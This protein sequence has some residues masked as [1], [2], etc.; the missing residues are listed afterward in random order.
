MA[1]T[2]V[3]CVPSGQTAATVLRGTPYRI[4]REEPDLRLVILSPLVRD[5]A[6]VAEFSGPGVELRELVMHRPARLEGR[7]LRL[8]QASHLR[9]RPTPG[10]RVRHDELAHREGR[11]AAAAARALLARAPSRVWRALNDRLAPDRYY[12]DLFRTFRPALVL[13]P[14]PG[15]NFAELP[16]LKRARAAGVPAMAIDTSWD[17]FTRLEPIR[18]VDRLAV[19]NTTM[20]R[21]A[22]ELHGYPREAIDVCGVPQFD[23]YADPGLRSPREAFMRR[24]GGDPGRRLITLATSPPLFY[25]EHGMLVDVIQ[26]AQKR[27]AFGV[28]TQLLIRPHPADP[29]APYERHAELDHVVLDRPFRPSVAAFGGM[30]VDVMRADRLHLADTL[31]HSDVVVNVSSTVTVEACV[32]DRPTINVVFDG[33]EQR[34]YIESA[35]RLV[36]YDHYRDIVRAG[37]V[38]LA[39]SPHELIDQI[40]HYLRHPESDRAGRARVVAEQCGVIDG[41]AGERLARA[42]LARLGR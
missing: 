32:F 11:R 16:L 14:T 22:I 21:Q 31:V 41:R 7:L 6:F 18:R 36:D 9:E 35:R 20:R 17:N 39:R 1:R 10:R 4:L 30:T 19:W 8:L 25:R 26:D 24:I 23:I 3:L 28:P 37:G 33:V 15:L 27:E 42:I 5:P 29:V 38:R 34:P 12:A 40:R 2:I 13:V